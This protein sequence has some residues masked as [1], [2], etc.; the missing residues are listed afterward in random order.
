MNGTFILFLLFN[1]QVCLCKFAALEMCVCAPK[2]VF[3]ITL[4]VFYSKVMSFYS[5]RLV[6]VVIITVFSLQVHIITAKI[7]KRAK[8]NGRKKFETFFYF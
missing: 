6:F 2:Y 3:T 5:C 1:T 7:K 4:G 8:K